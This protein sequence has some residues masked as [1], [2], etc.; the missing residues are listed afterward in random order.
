MSGWD[1]RAV[2]LI[3]LRG[4]ETD[5]RLF[6]EEVAVQEWEVL[7]KEGPALTPSAEGDCSYVVELRFRGSSYRAVTG[8][9]ERLEDLSDRLVL[10]LVVEAVQ[11][12]ERDPLDLP[13]W[14]A[15]EPPRLRPCTTPLPLR[16]RFRERAVDWWTVTFGPRDSGRQ[17]RALDETGARALAGRALPGAQS[18]PPAVRVRRSMGTGRHPDR[19][20]PSRRRGP[21]RQF[22]M[23]R[24][25]VLLALVCGAWIGVLWGQGVGAWWP[26]LPFLAVAAA[27]AAVVLRRV[28]PV[29]SGP[30]VTVAGVVLVGGVAGVGANGVVTAPDAVT[31]FRLVVIGLGFGYLVGMGV[32]LLVRQSS[33]RRTLPWLLPALLPLVAVLLPGLGL[34][35]P[36]AYLDAFELDLEDV[37]VP[38]VWRM[39]G[40]LRVAVAL[41]LWLLAPALIGYAKHLHFLV[42][43][44]WMLYAVAAFLSLYCVAQGAW[45]LALEPAAASGS[46]AV[47]AAAGGRTPAFYYGIKPEW[48]CVLPVTDVAKVPVE[49]GSLDPARAYLLMGDSGGAAVL[50]DA[51]GRAA[52]KVPLASVRLVPADAPRRPC[53]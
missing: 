25:P 41:T 18:A 27:A 47:A 19:H 9:R 38:A 4:T 12:V 53:P 46:R 39:I 40:A 37:D 34:T 16:E 52:L 35:L 45:S 50:W 33:W 21:M 23:L 13:V 7:E 42:R 29:L 5:R 10:D 17:V 36:A 3:A 24:F 11:L 48:M 28:G 1:L 31:G 20:P 44:R 14:Y 6:E 30:F 26:A 49:G 8:A 15:Y 22:G 32:W 43:D 2:A 51:W